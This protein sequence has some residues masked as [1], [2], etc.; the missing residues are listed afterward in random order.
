VT[1]RRSALGDPVKIGTF[2]YLPPTL[3]LKWNF[4]PD[5]RFRPYVGVGSPL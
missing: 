3:A 5:G 2:K 4:I 1:A